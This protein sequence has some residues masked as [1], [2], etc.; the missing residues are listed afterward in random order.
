[1][2]RTYH[3]FKQW[4]RKQYPDIDIRPVYGTGAYTLNKALKPEHM[5]E[6][7]VQQLPSGLY[8]VFPGLSAEQVM[9]QYKSIVLNGTP[10]KPD[11]AIPSTFTS[12]ESWI[13]KKGLKPLH[14]TH[15]TNIS[16]A[17]AL[18]DDSLEHVKRNW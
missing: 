18:H 2:I 11:T 14:R 17:D 7:M 10:V 13:T 9:E 5:F 1:M 8:I 15:V 16:A 4:V 6:Y 3:N 12:F